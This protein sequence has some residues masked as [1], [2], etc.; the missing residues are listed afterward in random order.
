MWQLQSSSVSLSNTL[1]KFDEQALSTCHGIEQMKRNTGP[2]EA[3]LNIGNLSVDVD[4]PIS[5]CSLIPS[6]APLSKGTD[7][8]EFKG[9]SYVRATR[10]S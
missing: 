6:S 5:L 2:G 10:C 3:C 4:T 9:S 1:D 8:Q 7:I